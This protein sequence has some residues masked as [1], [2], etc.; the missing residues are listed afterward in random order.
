M[1][2][3]ELHANDRQRNL[4]QLF[5]SEPGDAAGERTPAECCSEI[6]ECSFKPEHDFSRI[7][8]YHGYL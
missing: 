7:R 4:G 1:S 2:Q 6:A 5:D 3:S 8:C